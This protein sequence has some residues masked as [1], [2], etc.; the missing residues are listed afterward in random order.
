MMNSIL[1]NKNKLFIILFW[2]LVW[3]ILSLI[4]GHHDS[5]VKWLRRHPLTVE[6]GVR[7]PYGL[8][9]GHTFCLA[10]GMSLNFSGGLRWI[11]KN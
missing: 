4:I 10:E 8:F 11:I 3:E 1:R 7:L 2:I 9:R 6:T 5:L